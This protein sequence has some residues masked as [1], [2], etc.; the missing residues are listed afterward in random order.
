MGHAFLWN[1]YI[2]VDGEVANEDWFTNDHL[3]IIQAHELGHHIAG[4]NLIE[5]SPG[6]ER[7]ADWIGFN[8]LKKDIQK[9]NSALELYR[10]EYFARYNIFPES[11]DHF[12][13]KV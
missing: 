2:A 11:D 4:H 6:F 9:N 8:I 7:E 10:D 1:E 5:Y 12:E 3:K 13:Y